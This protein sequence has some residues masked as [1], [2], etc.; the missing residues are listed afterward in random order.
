VATALMFG[1]VPFPASLVGIPIFLVGA[2]SIF[3]RWWLDAKQRANTAYGV[4]SDRVLI[5]T[6]LPR[7][8]VKCR[9]L[10][11]ISDLS[12]SERR[13]IGDCLVGAV[14]YTVW[15][16]R[17]VCRSQFLGSGARGN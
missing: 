8:F 2:Y 4:T 11:A 17:L 5:I 9:N 16:L 13:R 14:E 1:L 3:G 12:L 7:R 15:R 6:A 10:S